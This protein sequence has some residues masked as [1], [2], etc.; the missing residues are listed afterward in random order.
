[1]LGLSHCRRTCCG[2]P[3]GT[4]GLRPTDIVDRAVT[5][6]ASGCSSFVISGRYRPMD[7]IFLW[8]G[9]AGAALLL[10]AICVAWW[11]HLR[12]MAD[13]ER[14]M[15]WSEQSRFALEARARE[16]DARLL[17]MTAVLHNQ[18]ANPAGAG[19]VKPP[20]ASPASPITAAT[21]QTPPARVPAAPELPQNRHSTPRPR[22]SPPFAE[23]A[24]V[25]QPVHHPATASATAAA[26]IS[27]AAATSS[28]ARDWD[29]ER[30]TPFDKAPRP[31]Q[32]WADTEPMVLTTRA[33]DF[34]PTMP[35]ELTPL[36]PN[37][38]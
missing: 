2:R 13:I 31:V 22:P 18:F 1:M 8:L 11:E 20:A 17:A 28:S 29:A 3:G 6:L 14:Q 33:F 36:E 30:T 24:A 19:A 10:V 35:V 4:C 26:I 16:V 15:S 7:S 32:T 9:A 25:H 23:A 21:T 34:P 27:A 5:K 37:G 12:R 38:R